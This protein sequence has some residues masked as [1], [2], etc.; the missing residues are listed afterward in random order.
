M[1]STAS[2]LI[3]W[4]GDI[5]SLPVLL[6][7]LDLIHI[8]AFCE[9]SLTVCNLDIVSTHLSLT[10]ASIVGKCPILETIRT[11]PL[12]FFIVPLIPKLYC[13]LDILSVSPVSETMVGRYL[14]VS[15]SKELLS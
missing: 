2:S 3:D 12:M 4:L 5:A 6:V 15:E 9:P 10:H 11:P 7:D 8:H 14:V 1:I 13:N